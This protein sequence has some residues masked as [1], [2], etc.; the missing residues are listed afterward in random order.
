MLF[1]VKTKNLTIINVSRS[2]NMHVFEVEISTIE[3]LSHNGL[4]QQGEN[5]N[6]IH[7]SKWITLTPRHSLSK[8]H[9]LHFK[10]LRILSQ[11]L[12]IV[13]AIR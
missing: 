6:L 5:N 1:F 8:V 9:R 2:G 13:A 3:R 12:Q 4:E 10:V 11:P 7:H